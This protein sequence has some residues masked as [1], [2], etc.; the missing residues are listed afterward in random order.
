MEE[1]GYDDD[2]DSDS[3]FNPDD[4]LDDNSDSDE[5]KKPLSEVKWEAGNRVAARLQL[6][7]HWSGCTLVQA[8]LR[9][10]GFEPSEETSKRKILRRFLQESHNIKAD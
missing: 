2:G 10:T 1:I 3:N 9:R 8:R 7:R 5:Q 4:D 6:H